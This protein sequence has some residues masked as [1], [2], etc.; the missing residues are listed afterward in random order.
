[1][2]EKFPGMKVYT[3]ILDAEVDARGFIIPGFGDA[4]DR[5][6]GTSV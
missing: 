3:G 4:G 1:M 5:S 2:S 6:F